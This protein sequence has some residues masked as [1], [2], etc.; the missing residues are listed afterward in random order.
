MEHEAAPVAFS[1]LNLVLS[2]SN[3]LSLDTN[4]RSVTRRTRS[5]GNNE[6]DSVE[7]GL[8]KLGTMCDTAVAAPGVHEKGMKLDIFCK[9]NRAESGEDI[10]EDIGVEGVCG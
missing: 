5:P 2:C 7:S 8:E 10:I 1:R 6:A 9:D 4:L 3:C